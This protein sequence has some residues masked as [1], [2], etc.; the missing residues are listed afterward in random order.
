MLILQAFLGQSVVKSHVGWNDNQPQTV[1]SS[2]QTR[3]RRGGI[4]FSTDLLPV[5]TQCM[6]GIG[7]YY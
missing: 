2:K 1:I 3:L 7:L 4:C 5:D 6:K